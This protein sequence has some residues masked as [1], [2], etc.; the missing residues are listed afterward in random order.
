M[1][2]FERMPLAGREVPVAAAREPDGGPDRTL[3]GALTGLIS[4]A[5]GGGAFTSSGK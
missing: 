1:I 5:T 3:I 2:A 4:A